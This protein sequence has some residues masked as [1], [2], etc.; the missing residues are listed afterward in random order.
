M[1]TKL[2]LY[3]R[4]LRYLGEEK[5]SSVSEAVEPRYRLDD[6]YDEGFID[7]VLQAGLWNFAMRTREVSYN[8]GV[9]PTFGYR[10]AFDKPSDFIRLGRISANE[11]FSDPLTQ[12]QDDKDYWMCSLQT[13]YVRYVSNDASYGGDIANWPAN[14]FKFAAYALANEVVEA[15]TH[16]DKLVA[17]VENNMQQA[18]LEAQNVDAM[19]QPPGFPPM[20]SWVRS[21]GGG[22]SGRRD[23]GNRGSLIG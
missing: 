4:A 14:F 6:A 5:L 15:F 13:I 11:Y 2:Q 18:L 19:N 20:G 16:N 7:L 17:K 21:R 8:S 9:S 3:N 10:F 12:Y 22:R 23:L 1:A